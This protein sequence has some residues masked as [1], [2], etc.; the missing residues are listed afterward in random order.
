MSHPSLSIVVPAYNEEAR[1]EAALER[2][3]GCIDERGWDA[4]VLI[5]DDG[6]KDQTASL[7]EQWMERHPRLH[8]IKNSGNRGKGHSIRNGILQAAGDIVMFTD[9]DLSAPMVEAER[10]VTALALGA[11]VAIGSRWLDRSR[12]TVHQPLYRQF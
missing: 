1:I 2:I 11:D 12:Q 3:L 8:L 7:V 10:L 5:V 6:S 4:E 9:S